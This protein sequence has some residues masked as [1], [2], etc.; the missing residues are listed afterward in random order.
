MGEHVLICGTNWLGDTIMS[1][2]AVSLFR[3]RNP[4]LRITVLV[5]SP[6]A[7]LWR[8]HASVDDVMEVEQGLGGTLRA[9]KGIRAAD[10]SRAFVFPNSFRST[11]IPSLAGVNERVGVRGQLRT[12][13]LTSILEPPVSD[14][15]REHQAWE[16]V[17]ILGM[18]DYDGAIAAPTLE[19]GE[20]LIE[21][22]RQKIEWNKG[23]TWVAVI[24]GAARGPSKMW[25]ADCFAKVAADTISSHA[26]RIMVLGTPDEAVLCRKVASEIGDSAINLAGA[27]SLSEVVAL[28]GMCRAVVTNDSGGM[29]VA[30]AGG[31]RVVAVFGLT[32]P[33]KTGP[34]GSGHKVLSAAGVDQSRDIPR[35]SVKARE[36]LRSIVPDRVS[37]EVRKILEEER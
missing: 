2:P 34:L 7:A 21:S 22:C 6:L 19:T 27:T 32:D 11:L 17:H 35:D 14:S 31:A 12:W 25:P 18:D 20:S 23:D 10:F 24:P 37:V 8:M 4:G 29:H 26:A 13:M 1:M 9:A 3:R 15:D 30:T 28:S 33:A 16:Y 5:R 36:C